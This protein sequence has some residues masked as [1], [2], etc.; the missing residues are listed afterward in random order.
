M[1]L[2]ELLNQD[3]DKEENLMDLMEPPKPEDF[4]KA[5]KSDELMELLTRGFAK[6]QKN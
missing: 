4:D 5:G 2:M 1:E 3:S 6:Q